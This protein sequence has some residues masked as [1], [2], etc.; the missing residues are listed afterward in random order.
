MDEY[1]EVERR[2]K[3]SHK[4]TIEDA[5]S[6]PRTAPLY[7]RP[8]REFIDSWMGQFLFKTT[9]EIIREL[10]PEPLVPNPDNLMLIS[11]NRCNVSGFGSFNEVVLAAPSAFNEITGQ[12][13]VC[14]YTDEV[15]PVVCGREV[16]G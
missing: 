2:R 12:Y 3:V 4:S 16:W 8:P 7:G 5:Y 14:L 10:V 15:M 11:L 1:N 9:S 13:A 6:I